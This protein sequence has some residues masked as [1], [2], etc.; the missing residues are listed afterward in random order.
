MHEG[1]HGLSYQGIAPE[2]GALA[3]VRQRVARDRRV[4][5]P[6]VGEPRRPLAAVLARVLPGGAAA[7][8]AARARS[9]WTT[10]T[11]ASTASSRG[12]IRVEADEVTYSLH[13]ILRFELEQ[14]LVAGTLR[15]RSCRRPGTR[16]CPSFLGVEVP[17]DLRGV[18][19]D[20]HWTR[21]SYGYFPTY[22]LGNVL[23]VQIWRALE[24]EHAD[25]DAL[26]ESG[27]L[28]GLYE[29]LRAAALP[30]RP[31]VHAAGDARAGDRR[32]RDRPAAV[33]RVPALEGR[34]ARAP[35]DRFR[36]R[37]P[38]GRL[39]DG[40]DSVLDRSQPLIESYH[41]VVRAELPDDIEIFD[42][43]VHLGHRRRRDGRRLR[44][45][46]RGPAALR[47]LR[48]VRLLPRRARPPPRLPRRERPHARVR[49]ALGGPVRPVRPARPR[50]GPDRRG[51][52]AAS[53][54][55]RAGSSSTRGRRSSC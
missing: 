37:A 31:E 26:L 1:G 35:P 50:R 34:G 12:L 10:S 21:P 36:P 32:D 41:A 22:A 16:G 44:R 43:H 46:R 25:L 3:A 15:P 4:A 28:V 47:D 39:Q 48:R 55:A 14:Q 30:P 52:A 53:T 9:S 13:I 51:D 42:A 33:P 20:V 5:E 23:S 18:L 40:M 2:L 17:D 54:P 8:P 27:E 19:Q 6:D 11:A 7:L 45:A 29:L 38:V 49:A 24:E